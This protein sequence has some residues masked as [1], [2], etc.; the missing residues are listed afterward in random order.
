MSLT[1]VGSPGPAAV[2]LAEALAHCRVLAGQD[3]ALVQMYIEAAT[4]ACA[5]YLSRPIIKQQY[6]LVISELSDSIRIEG[7]GPVTIDGVWYTPVAG[8]ETAI[9]DYLAY[10]S[11]GAML[12]DPVSSWPINVQSARVRFTAGFDPIPFIVRAA[13]LL[14]V[15]SLYANRESETSGVAGDNLARKLDSAAHRLLLPITVNV[16]V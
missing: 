13:I 12:I 14:E 10:W 11:T 8:S 5:L 15:G 7:L 9:T 16:G 2:T 4:E 3:D 1:P 6:D